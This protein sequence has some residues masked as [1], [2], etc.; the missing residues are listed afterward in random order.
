MPLPLAKKQELRRP[1]AHLSDLAARVADSVAL[2]QHAEGPGDPCHPVDVCGMDARV[3]GWEEGGRGT[4][5][6]ARGGGAG[7]GGST[8]QTSSAQVQGC[9]QQ[10]WHVQGSQPCA[11]SC[12][13]RAPLSPPTLDTRPHMPLLPST[14]HTHTAPRLHPPVRSASYAITT[15]SCA[16]SCARSA[17]R[18]PGVPL[19]C[20]G[21][22]VSGPTNLRIS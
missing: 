17:A 18:S 22:S 10:A 3:A 19:Y 11:A 7:R 13:R 15:T 20:S 14:T 4:G 5:G 9:K 2:V 12:K 1:P 8:P 16:L 21:R 6:A